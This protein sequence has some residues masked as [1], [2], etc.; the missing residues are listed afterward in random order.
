MGSSRGEKGEFFVRPGEMARGRLMVIIVRL[1]RIMNTPTTLAALA[2]LLLA[3][4][5][6]FAA[7]D[8]GSSTNSTPYDPYMRP[9][10]E[11]LVGLHGSAARID[12]V[13]NYMRTS[14]SFRYSFT[15]PYIAQLPAVTANLK[16]GDCKA[17]SLWLADQ[18][19]DRNVRF[20][21][22]KATRASKISHAWLMWNDGSR[23]WVLDPT[24][25]RA[26]I[27]ADSTSRDEYIPL[28]SYDK[29]HSYRHA[30]TSTYMAGV[31]SRG[32]AVAAKSSA[33]R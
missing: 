32:S 13:K 11:V 20:V 24:N 3:K 23:W 8:L 4:A 16:S 22:G 26:P 29:G 2:V 25:Q 12:D 5:S 33:K 28:Y 9:V 17:K 14:H 15:E 30:A 1:I 31:A 19:D 18:L 21:I 6:A 7:F 10:K 27:P